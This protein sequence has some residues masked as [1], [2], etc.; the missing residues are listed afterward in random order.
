M[1]SRL[2]PRFVSLGAIIS[3]YFL[4][5]KE[6]NAFVQQ[7]NYTSYQPAGFLSGIWHGLLAPWSLIARWFFDGVEMYAY[8]NTGWFYDFGFLLGIPA[9]LPIGWFFAL[10]SSVLHLFS[11]WN[12]IPS[13]LLLLEWQPSESALALCGHRAH[14]PLLCPVRGNQ[15]WLTHLP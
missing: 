15:Q 11:F 10:I 3:I 14:N 5:P 7:W 2:I 13:K 8:A 9:S 12:F 6:G 4:Y 1:G